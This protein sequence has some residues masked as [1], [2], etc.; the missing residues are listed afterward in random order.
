MSCTG[1]LIHSIADVLVTWEPVG[2]ITGFADGD[3]VIEIQPSD[4][5][6]NQMK[7]S[8]D[9]ASATLS[10]NNKRNGKIVIKLQPGSSMIDYL[11]EL[12]QQDRRTMGLMVVAN[13]RNGKTYAM[14]CAV[15]ENL[16][17]MSIG[18]EPADSIDFTF[19]YKTLTT[20]PGAAAVNLIAG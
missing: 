11:T 19:L 1:I 2:D 9:G 17:N 10:G 3:S 13:I 7:V 15:L 12:W 4:E 8:A 6:Q 20:T 14:D 16:P 5:G 18:D